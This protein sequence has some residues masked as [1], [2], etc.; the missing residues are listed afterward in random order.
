MLDGIGDIVSG[1]GT[2]FDGVAMLQKMGV[3]SGSGLAVTPRGNSSLLVGGGGSSTSESGHVG[4]NAVGN[5]K[6]SDVK[7]STLQEANDSKKKQMVEA[8]EEEDA[9]QADF[10]S[11]TTLKIFELLDEVVHGDNTIKVKVMDYGLTKTGGKGSSTLSGVDKI[12]NS[13]SLSSSSTGRR[14]G[15]SSTSNNGVT[16]GQAGL[17]FNGWS[18]I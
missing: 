12:T 18:I 8:Q 4:G 2:S 10:L 5:A 13:S 14:G 6:G 1:L 15:A 3:G 16:G 11:M 7:D 17:I 9:H